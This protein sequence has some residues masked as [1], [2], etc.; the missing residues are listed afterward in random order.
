LEIGDVVKRQLKNG[1][2]GMLNRQPTLWKGSK[3][4]QKIVIG[5]FKTLRF[6]LAIT[7]PMNAD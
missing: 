7:K 1:D 5:P 2:I 6:N 3:R 4:A